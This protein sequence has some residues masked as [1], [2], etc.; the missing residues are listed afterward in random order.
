M[1][2]AYR[3]NNG[4]FMKSQRL[5]SAAR[6]IANRKLWA[7][8]LLLPFFQASHAQQ[9]AA[10]LPANPS[11][12]AISP[13]ATNPNQAA[14]PSS[15]DTQP[16]LSPEA[17]SRPSPDSQSS[18]L[19]PS[20]ATA[21]SATPNAA[22]SQSK[23]S[24]Q[25]VGS[26]RLQLNF[27]DAEI[28]AVAAA[29]S[30]LLGRQILVDA[31]VKGRMSLESS[32]PL[33]KD[34]ALALFQSALRM[35][36]FAMVHVGDSLRV[37]PEVDAK[38]HGGPVQQQA[39][40][41]RSGEEV[42]TRVFRLRYELANNI[43]PIIRPLVPPNNTISAMAS[44]NSLVVTDYSSNL[45]RIAQLIEELDAPA[46]ADFVSI[47]IKHAS[48]SEVALLVSRL[49]EA[50]EVGAN[51][52]R[53]KVSLVPE[54]R[55]NALLVR[56]ASPARI[57]QVRQL[58]D[59]VDQPSGKPGNIHVVYLKNAEATRLAQTLRGILS[60]EGTSL[61][62]SLAGASGYGAPG[63]M[64]NQGLGGGSGGL[65]NAGAA[66]QQGL[67]SSSMGPNAMGGAA[68]GFAGTGFGAS[69]QGGGALGL[70]GQ[71]MAMGASQSGQLGVAGASGPASS[72][73]R[74]GAVV[75][76]ADAAT[77]SLIITASEPVFRDIRAVIDKLDV[78]RAQVYIESLIVEVNADKAAELGFQW[79]FLNGTVSGASRAIGGTNLSARGEGTNILDLTT[80]VLGAAQGLNIGVIRNTPL[81]GAGSNTTGLINLGVLANALQSR[82]NGNV[83]ATPNLL[84]LDN[85]EARIIIG[86]NVPFVTGSYVNTGAGGG[87]VNPFQTVERRDVGTTLRVRPQ[88]SE[89]GTVKLAIYQEVSSIQDKTLSAGLITNRRAIESN[90]LVDDGQII[91]LGGLIEDRTSGDTQSVPLL[92]DIPIAGQLFRYDARSRNKTNLLVFLRPR[93]LRSAEAA[94]ALT[95]DR[96]EFMRAVQQEQTLPGAVLMPKQEAPVL[97]E[98]PR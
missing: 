57:E 23:G 75:I 66:A 14:S 53:L 6:R 65:T 16:R 5:R 15:S 50:S 46:K 85:E 62:G 54:P 10:L 22:P 52:A 73:N 67:G 77:N 87:V 61:G 8:L 76:A 97:P 36:L 35:Q 1:N 32:R 51:D 34:Q 4:K 80:N 91:V 19:S 47:A 58:I 9:P 95:Q 71:S 41:A 48:A 82:A 74:L 88:V 39:S 33:T 84:T 79:Q 13:G 94:N 49:L 86:Q 20:L 60:G 38:L 56:S 68:A 90:V 93:V 31:R 72:I 18:G 28:D 12:Q 40:S 42:I 43:L 37:V 24:I 92:G 45:E 96:Y 21:P 83:L 25:R 11:A 17:Q 81:P 78:R 27:R 69:P 26:D 29:F 3:T 2:Q 98:V 30:Q 70:G 44:N 64:M 7:A 63:A 89:G 55:S 59:Q